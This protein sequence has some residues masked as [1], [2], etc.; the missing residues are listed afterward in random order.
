M[1]RVG[2]VVPAPCG[3]W[4]AVVVGRMD[5]EG[6]KYTHD[7]WQVSLTDPTAEPVQITTGEKNDRSPRFRHDGALC[8]LSN[9]PQQEAE[10]G[11]PLTQ[12]WCMVTPEAAPTCL[13]DEPLGV[14]AFCFADSADRLVWRASRLPG[15]PDDAQRATHQARGKS[16]TSAHHYRTMPVRFWDHWLGPAIPRLY[17]ADGHGAHPTLLTPDA[18]VHS[19]LEAEFRV[20]PDGRWVAIAWQR[21]GVDRV[22]DG[23]LRVIDLNTGTDRI[24]GDLPRINHEHIR[25][26]PDSARIATA[27]HQRMDGALGQAELVVVDLDSGEAH[28]VEANWTDWPEPIG[29]TADGRGLLL[30]MQINGRADVLQVNPDTGEVVPVLTQDGCHDGSTVSGNLL[31]GRHHALL[32]APAPFVARLDAVTE[33]RRMGDLACTPASLSGSATWS[34]IT[35]EAD[36]GAP[37]QAFI[38]TPPGPGPHPVLFWVHGGPISHFADWWH[39]RWNPLVFAA[40]G[41]AVVLPNPRGSRGFG[42]DFIEGIW[43]NEWGAACFQDLMRVADA[44][45]T[46]ADLDTDRM[47]AMGA[48]FGGYMMNWF[49]G[50]TDR[51]G[52][53]V[54]HAGIFD[55]SAFYGA[56]DLPAYL[57]LQ[58]AGDPYSDP[59]HHDR[60]SPH[61]F[62][63]SWQTP[64]LVIHGEKDYRCPIGDGLSLF[65]ALQLHG[66][67]SELLVFPDENHWIQRPPNVIAWY[68]AIVDFLHRHI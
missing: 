62:M 19:L 67:P 21:P 52:C 29:W 64:T 49:G 39:W 38:V 4:A 8:F 33:R 53:L 65:E 28:T 17:A 25:F 58:M 43:N 14:E 57:R 34:E 10:E 37:I 26:S 7:L 31:V 36:D 15:V 54:S 55:M 32:Q 2:E 12:I 47:G 22:P 41:Y 45:E 46:R 3:T 27:R 30:R 6:A 48:S 42:P 13:T 40:Q 20:S 44:L 11:E 23:V 56:T 18:E 9:R 16:G 24:L 51:F 60:Y 5:E 63:G 50:N 66:I 35:V 59:A 61:R 68:D 1:G